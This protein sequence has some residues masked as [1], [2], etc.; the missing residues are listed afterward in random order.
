MSLLLKWHVQEVAQK[1][2]RLSPNPVEMLTTCWDSYSIHSRP[3]AST[4]ETFSSNL[5]S[6]PA[7]PNTDLKNP[8]LRFFVGSRPAMVQQI[9]QQTRMPS[10]LPSLGFDLIPGLKLDFLVEKAYST[11]HM[12]HTFPSGGGASLRA[13]EPS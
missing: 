4:C 5:P 8:L 11:I 9:N 6:L 2:L 1:G 12:N 7:P 3:R 10:C 13:Y